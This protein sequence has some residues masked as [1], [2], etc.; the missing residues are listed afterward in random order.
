MSKTM[1]IIFFLAVFHLIF[2]SSAYQIE[3]PNYEMLRTQH[4]LSYNYTFHF[5]DEFEQP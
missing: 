5:Y 1:P 4:I 3:I 2:L